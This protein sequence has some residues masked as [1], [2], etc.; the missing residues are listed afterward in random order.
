M[1]KTN[2]KILI[3]G[4]SGL[5]GRSLKDIKP[6]FTYLSSKD[7]NLCDQAE[8]EKTL[9]LYAPDKILHLAA[10]VGGI[11]WNTESPYDF[12][13]INNTMNTNVI[14]YCVKKNI[15]IIFSSS[16]CVYPK[17]ARSYPMTEDMVNDGEPE[18]T[19]DSYAYSKRFA[20]QM[21]QAA[22]K[23]YG[24]KYCT[25]YFCNLYGEYDEFHNDVKS[26]LVTALIKK[27]Y[28]AK[29]KNLPEVELWGTGKP[30]RQFMYAGDAAK[31]LIKAHELDLQGDYN[32]AIPENLTISQIANIVKNIIEFQGDIRYNGNLDGIF[33]K[34]VSSDKL[35]NITGYFNFASLESGVRQ[36]CKKLMETKNVEIN[37]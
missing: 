21:L 27:F 14:N 30:M 37:A 18:P 12:I 22:H 25:L 35:I 5:L 36:V 33:R 24:L 10:R 1:N 28:N 26:H 31:I 34:D 17:E 20:G 9:D 32:A 6:E 8:V 16:T 13:H 15:P 4:G 23:Q 2:Q 3:T 19:N 7:V 29:L 11:K